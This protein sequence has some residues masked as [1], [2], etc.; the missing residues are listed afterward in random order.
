MHQRSSWREEI[1]NEI[2][3]HSTIMFSYAQHRRL[4]IITQFPAVLLIDNVN[5]T[6]QISP[7]LTPRVGITFSRCCAFTSALV[8]DPKPNLIVS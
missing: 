5:V 7:V 3:M 2:K 4:V 1:L 8:I 6:Y